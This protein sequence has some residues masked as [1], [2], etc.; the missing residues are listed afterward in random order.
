MMSDIEKEDFVKQSDKNTFD[1]RRL[2]FTIPIFLAVAICSGIWEAATHV[3]NYNR[4]E[5]DYK[6]SQKV[7]SDSMKSFFI[8]QLKQLRTK[9]STDIVN[10]TNAEVLRY[11]SLNSKIDI[12]KERC[13][14]PVIMGAVT[15]KRDPNNGQITMQPYHN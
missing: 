2:K 13:K 7:Q 8:T 15:E 5:I 12:I 6:K 14:R 11:N 4:D 9:D 1:I 3:T 10:A